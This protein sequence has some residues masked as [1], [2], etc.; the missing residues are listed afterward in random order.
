VIVEPTVFIVGAGASADYGFP[1]GGQLVRRILSLTGDETNE[2]GFFYYVFEEGNVQM[3]ADRLRGS[4][5]SSIDTF[6]EGSD[7]WLVR[8]GKAAIGFAIVEAEKKALDSS[9]IVGQP[10][11]DHWLG[12]IWNLLRSGCTPETLSRN[13]VAF[14]TFN[15]DR[16][17]EHYLDT[18][19]ANSF[20]LRKEE[21][22]K[23]R[24]QAFPI[25]HLHGTPQRLRFGSYRLDAAVIGAAGEGIR[26][27]HDSPKEDDPTFGSAYD[28]LQKA[29]RVVLLG[30]G[31]HPVNIERLRLAELLRPGAL[32]V[33]SAYQ[34]GDA[35]VRAAERR[36]NRPCSIPT[37]SRKCSDFLRHSVELF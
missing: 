7:D 19:I 21:A 36:I 9:L 10:P 31:Y 8:I 34:L 26:V 4:D 11:G 2:R 25:I 20:G 27:V 18:V 15:Y 24:E 17:L 1:L 12:Y 28:L 16:V 32:V 22:T 33:G 30:F 14:V 29:T 37:V 6:L 3:F 5:A 23:C 13:Q 35:E